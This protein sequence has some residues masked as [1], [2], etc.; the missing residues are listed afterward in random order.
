MVAVTQ[1]SDASNSNVFCHNCFRNWAIWNS[2]QLYW[3]SIKQIHV[4]IQTGKKKVTYFLK[5]R[6]EVPRLLAIRCWFSR[7]LMCLK[8]RGMTLASLG[9]RSQ[10]PSDPWFPREAL[11]AHFVLF[12]IFDTIPFWEFEWAEARAVE[13]KISH[14]SLT[15]IVSCPQSNHPLWKFPYQSSG[16]GRSWNR[17]LCAC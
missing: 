4:E 14:C 5:K 7:W 11:V 3:N 6:F 15:P 10:L 2:W 13:C 17:Y 16:S 9:V 12:A 1:N 8:S